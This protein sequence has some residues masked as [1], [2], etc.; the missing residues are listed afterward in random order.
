[1]IDDIG[2]WYIRESRMNSL[3]LSLALISPFEGEGGH[4]IEAVT[5]GMDPSGFV[6]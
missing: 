4:T 3:N 6:V 1:M 2:Q 5:P